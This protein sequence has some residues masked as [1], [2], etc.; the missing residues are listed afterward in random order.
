MSYVCNF[1][2]NKS[3]NYD[4][5]KKKKKFSYLFAYVL[6]NDETI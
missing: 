2:R 1:Q 4:V 3:E 6:D 5:Q